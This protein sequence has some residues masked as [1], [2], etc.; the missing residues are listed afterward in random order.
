[1]KT[2]SFSAHAASCC[3]DTVLQRQKSRAMMQARIRSHATWQADTHER[4]RKAFYAAP[5]ERQAMQ[6]VSPGS[7]P[8]ATSQTCQQQPIATP[9]DVCEQLMRWHTSPWSCIWQ[10]CSPSNSERLKQSASPLSCARCRRQEVSSV[11]EQQVAARRAEEAAR[12]LRDRQCFPDNHT[13][14]VPQ[15]RARPWAATTQQL[16]AH[17]E[18]CAHTRSE[19]LLREPYLLA[20][21]EM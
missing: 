13:A 17:E 2:A 12:V 8:T 4:M 10:T 15:D 14:P 16:T 5:D 11:L 9:G 1:M 20:Q 3:Q 19:T 6:C 21:P 18:V 7:N